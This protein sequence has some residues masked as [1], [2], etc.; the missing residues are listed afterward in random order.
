MHATQHFQHRMSQRGISRDMVEFVLD[1]G[2]PE[3]DK[4]ILGRKDAT[5]LLETF[6]RQAQLLKRILDKGGIEVVA[7]GDALV[8]TYNHDPKHGKHC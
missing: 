4:Y 1:H 2:R 5:Q 6:Q 7:V 8:T 3:K